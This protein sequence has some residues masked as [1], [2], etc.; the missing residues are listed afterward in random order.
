MLMEKRKLQND[1]HRI[2]R[3]AFM[4][5]LSTQNDTTLVKIKKKAWE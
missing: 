2:H 3:F 5:I 1:L 4:K